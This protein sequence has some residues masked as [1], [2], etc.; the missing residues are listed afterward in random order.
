MTSN[1]HVFHYF[2]VEDCFLNVLAE[3]SAVVQ[4][5]VIV[6]ALLD[7]KLTFNVC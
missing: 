4:E 7:R 1:F 2:R 3:V 6:W 5:L